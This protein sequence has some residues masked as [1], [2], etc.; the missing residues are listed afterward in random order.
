MINHILIPL[1][2][3][4]LAEIVLPYGKT[5]FKAFHPKVTLIHMLEKDPP[6]TIHGE[7]HLATEMPVNTWMGSRKNGSRRM[8]K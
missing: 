1:D 8:L 4:S 3:S 6:G 7:K 5:L 2:G